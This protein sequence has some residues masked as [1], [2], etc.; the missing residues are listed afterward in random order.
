MTDAV[1]SS[2]NLNDQL[3]IAEFFD[4]QYLSEPRYWWRDKERYAPDA[5]S[6]P[7]SLVTQMTLRLIGRPPGRVLDLGAGEG[8]DSIRLALL[9][10]DVSAVEISKVA[11]EKIS[12][13]AKE[14]NAT[15]NVEV[16]DVVTYEPKG[17]F[18]LIICNGVLHYIDD[19]K[20]VVDRMQAATRAGGI[21]VISLW[22]TYT[23]VP[24]CHEVVPV[25]CD[26]EHGLVVKMYDEWIKEM[27][28][29]DR[30]RVE[31]SH[32]GMPSHSHSHIKLIARKPGISTKWLPKS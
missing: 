9:G 23:P 24:E 2:G 12:M 19:K 11:A 17:D 30:N 16:A 5:D 4:A 6:Y 20:T 1:S 15:V 18:D 26:D 32:S 3:N 13:F 10:Y 27:L 7:F 31:T 14:A 21:N 25:S 8:A 28:Y 29:F 22:S